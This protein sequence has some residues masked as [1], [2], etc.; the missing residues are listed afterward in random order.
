[1]NLPENKA[2]DLRVHMNLLF[3]EHAYLVAKTGNA[4]AG[5]RTDE[6]TA[7]ATQLTK[8][9][10]DIQSLINSAGGANGSNAFGNIW[11]QYLGL[12]AAYTVGVVT[13]DD[14]KTAA[15]ASGLTGQ[16]TP[17]FS[18][19][20]APSQSSPDTTATSLVQQFV[21]AV[22]AVLDDEA[23]SAWTNLFA[24]IATA[25]QSASQIGDY[26][27]AK[28][29]GAFPDR[30][31]GTAA[32][33]A[34]NLR[35]A[36]NLDLQRLAYLG[37]MATAAVVGA[38][39]DERTG[40]TNQLTVTVQALSKDLARSKPETW[41]SWTTDLM[42]YA[43]KTQV[44]DLKQAQDQIT[45]DSAA[46]GRLFDDPAHTINDA[47]NTQT[48]DEVAV[49]DAQRLMDVNGAATRDRVAAIAMEL[50]AD[51]VTYALVK[52]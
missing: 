6:Y 16:F 27:G 3:S 14:A 28:F 12:V 20:L 51:A 25:A 1:M 39:A 38:R 40:A 7:Y 36:V 52:S 11:N 26:L 30:F 43:A 33:S 22:R 18:Q 34:F 45:N 31:P 19:Y 21:G 48:Q 47:V 2:A 15:A 49:V 37:T 5:G 4:A 24:D 8:N 23:A 17:A 13:H 29:I 50:I 44:G 32:G 42:S 46:L 10:D 41:N 35:L 9:S